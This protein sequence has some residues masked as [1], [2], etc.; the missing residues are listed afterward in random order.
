MNTECY[1]HIDPAKLSIA[2]SLLTSLK[3]LTAKDQEIDLSASD[4]FKMLEKPPE[5]KMG[6]YALP[7]FRFAKMLK[8]KPQE[9]AAT[10]K[11]SIES[12]NNPWI[13]NIQLAGAFLNFFTSKPQLAKSLLTKIADNSFFNLPKVNAEK[14]M[15]EFSQ[16]NTHKE[17]HVGHARNVCLGDSLSRILAYQGHDVT[18]VNYIGDEGA[19]IAKCLWRM[20]QMDEEVPEHHKAEW[21]G[22]R[23]VEANQALEKATVE[24]KEKY[25][26]EISAILRNL[27]NQDGE[28]YKIWQSSRED[29]LK[30]F[31]DI[32]SWLDVHFDH[33][34][35]ESEFS[36]SSQKL[37]D[38]YLANGL[39]HESNGAI[40]IDLS[41]YKLGFCMVRKSDGN[42][43][44]MTRDIALAEKKFNEFQVDRSV[45][46][47][48]SEQNYHFKQLFKTL[49]LIGFENAKKCYHLSYGMVTRPE[50]KMSSRKGNSI[51]FSQLKIEI[52]KEL[53]GYLARYEGDWSTEDISD[54]SHKLA[55]GAIKYGMLQADPAK[56]IVFDLKE[57]LSFEGDTGPYLMYSYARTQSIMRKAAEMGQKPSLDNLELL[58][59]DSEHELLR[60]M[61]DFNSNV[62]TAG[63]HYRPSTLAHHLFQMC[64]AF[65]RFYTDVSVLKA[66]SS[67]LMGGRLALL[68]GFAKTLKQGLNLLGITP[69]EKM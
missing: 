32:Y 67:T 37:V 11:T 27:E 34:F 3:A 5:S 17:F 61:Y 25:E 48:G 38:K 66:E 8:K 29:C 39:F 62:T 33:Y 65:N 21:Y 63:E 43:P 41:D 13:D 24:E 60:Y 7:C 15:V 4:L 45:Y 9:I 35:F 57:W 31:K 19:H 23:Y 28:H 46:V 59:N 54:I 18:P 40:G 2:N 1:R 10:L 68:E 55:V 51:S 36:D 44:Y 47:V 14:I 52:E 56:E 12:G 42:I 16:P 53:K 22:K 30:D 26:K 20:E 58:T 64:K 50:G 69:P 6:D 49:E